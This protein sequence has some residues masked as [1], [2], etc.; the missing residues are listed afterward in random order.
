MT[1]AA[2]RRLGCILLAA[3]NASCKRGTIGWM[4]RRP[5]LSVSYLSKGES[6]NLLGAEGVRRAVAPRTALVAPCATAPR[7]WRRR[8]SDPP[9]RG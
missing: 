7:P 2:V 9:L 8:R 4:S 5:D 1:A 3:V 6:V